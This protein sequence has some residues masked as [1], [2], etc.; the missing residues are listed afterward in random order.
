[1]RGLYFELSTNRKPRFRQFSA[2]G[3]ILKRSHPV[4]IPVIP[5]S[6]CHLEA[7]P[8]IWPS[9]SEPDWNELEWV[10]M[11]SEW[12]N[13]VLSPIRRQHWIKSFLPHSPSFLSHSIQI[14]TSLS[15]L[16]WNEL[17]W[18]W[19]RS[20][21]FNQVLMDGHFRIKAKPL[22]FF[23]MSSRPIRGLEF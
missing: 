4:L 7:I 19:M 11:R 8:N 1:M 14:R 23:S 17:G 5:P 20:E 10:E 15:E 2:A 13:P 12:F 16:D 21:W 22:D 9:L 6:F 18:D 3:S